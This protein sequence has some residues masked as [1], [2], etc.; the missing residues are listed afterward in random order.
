[1]KK[2][3][4]A[5]SLAIALCLG[6]HAAAD[7]RQLS[8]SDIQAILIGAT[9]LG[10]GGG[11]SYQSA[12]AAIN[13]TMAET[14]TIGLISSDD[15]VPDQKMGSVLGTI[16]SAEAVASL[17]AP[18]SLPV[19]A[20]LA[21]AT[22]M[23]GD[24]YVDTGFVS[25]HAQAP[26][27]SYLAAIEGGA[28]Q[29]VFPLLTALSVNKKLQTEILV[30]DMAGSDRAVPS[31]ELA[32]LDQYDLG[33]QIPLS[34]MAQSSEYA[35]AHGPDFAVVNSGGADTLEANVRHLITSVPGFPSP[36]NGAAGLVAYHTPAAIINPAPA[37][38][39]TVTDALGLGK[40]FLASRKAQ[41][42][43]AYLQQQGRVSA[44]LIADGHVTSMTQASDYGVTAGTIAL[45][46]Q[47]GT[48]YV[49]HYLNS[50][51]IMYLV[52]SGSAP[53]PVVMGPD[54]IGIVPQTGDPIDNQELYA[55]FKAGQAPV[56]SVIAVSVMGR[57]GHDS[58]V[59]T[60]W[61]EHRPGY[62]GT[63]QQPWHSSL[64]E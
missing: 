59:M 55:A 23:L 43:V 17:K 64:P 53:K 15:L 49:I 56:V 28:H 22:R 14:D 50:N 25:Y 29:A 40:A 32:V 44:V 4:A 30:I 10:S 16:G 45:T 24:G 61:R 21:Y 46:D 48:Q 54:I 34:V 9:L 52:Q 33:P 6:G 5:S 1:M 26:Q 31:L 19:N 39:G 13:G 60:A 42:L 12:L 3:I 58:Y 41:D 11:G 38:R 20:V 2:A 18:L 47:A 63:F 57:V 35:T 62:I 7:I 36:Y 8:K 37:L 51:A 27:V